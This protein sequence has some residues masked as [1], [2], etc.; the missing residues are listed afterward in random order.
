MNNPERTKTEGKK[1][2]TREMTWRVFEEV[3]KLDLLKDYISTKEKEEEFR[4]IM[5]QIR[6]LRYYDEEQITSLVSQLLDAI[7]VPED[8]KE[9]LLNEIKDRL[10][11]YFKTS[12][13]KKGT[14]FRYKIEDPQEV[15]AWL[16]LI[17]PKRE[18]DQFKAD[19]QKVITEG[20][21]FYFRLWPPSIRNV[22]RYFWG[23]EEPIGYQPNEFLEELKNY[24]KDIQE[25][26]NRITL[27]FDA[28]K[29]PRDL[30]NKPKKELE[31]LG[32][33]KV[34]GECEIY[35]TPEKIYQ[36]LN[37]TLEQ[38]L[39]AELLRYQIAK[40]LKEVEKLLKNNARFIKKLSGGKEL[41]N[42]LLTD[43]HILTLGFRNLMERGATEEELNVLKGNIE[44]LKKV[45]GEFAEDRKKKSKSEIGGK[46]KNWIMGAGSNILTFGLSSI[47]LWG[48]ALFWFLPLWM[49]TKM[50]ESIE[51]SGVFK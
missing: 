7:D 31:R 6:G 28:D 23:A 5:N 48:L 12:K 42:S 34:N 37:L 51:K 25:G 45:L 44:L 13:E 9:A 2:K 15:K 3:I 49:I 32:I 18:R 38:I 17:L 14:N 43:F 36:I 24:A 50:Y 39:P 46:I 40:E 11:V 41:Y 10:E 35:I 20:E 29:L 16:Y 4:K 8:K 30:K 26:K 21:P 22:F 1:S 33:H 19:F 27:V 47:G